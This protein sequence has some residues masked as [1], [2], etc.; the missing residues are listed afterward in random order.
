[1]TIAAPRASQFDT[2][3]SS[4]SLLKELPKQQHV[5]VLPKGLS[6][7]EVHAVMDPRMRAVAACAVEQQDPLREASFGVNYQILGNGVVTA[8]QI[9]G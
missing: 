2:V 7:E 4:F 6:P 5:V 9:E 8:V 1:V 3:E